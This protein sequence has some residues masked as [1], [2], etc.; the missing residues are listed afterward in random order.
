MDIYFKATYKSPGAILKPGRRNRG[1]ISQRTSHRAA[2]P[3]DSQDSGTVD[4]D[5]NRED[6]L[7]VAFALRL[8]KRRGFRRITP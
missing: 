1:Y 6:S 2:V 3:L 7:L 8:N 5:L 4:D